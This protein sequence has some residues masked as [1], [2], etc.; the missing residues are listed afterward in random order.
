MSIPHFSLPSPQKKNNHEIHQTHHL[1]RPRNHRRLHHPRP[2]PPNRRHQTP[3][4]RHRRNQKRAPQS[5]HSD[6]SRRKCR[7]WHLRY[8]CCRQAH[9]SPSR[10]ELRGLA[11]WLRFSGL[12]FRQLRRPDADRRISPLQH[13]LP[14]T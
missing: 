1:L 6:T 4:R 5:H 12:Q 10:Q 14:R 9:L 8:R 7:A 3:P 11:I 13:R 2:H